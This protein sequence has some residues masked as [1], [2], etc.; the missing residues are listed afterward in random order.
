MNISASQLPRLKHCRAVVSLPQYPSPDS[1]YSLRGK[2]IHKFIETGE[3]P[4]GYEDECSKIVLEGL[5]EGRHEVSFAWNSVTGE[6]RELGQGLGRKYD[7][8][9]DEIGGTVDLV[10]V[11]GTIGD[12]KT[13][14]HRVDPAESNWQ[15]A[16][17]ALCYARIHNLDAVQVSIFYLQED[18][19]WKSDWAKLDLFALAAFE[20]ELRE[21]LKGGEPNPG[22]WCRHCPSYSACPAKIGLIRSMVTDMKPVRIDPENAA[23]ALYKLQAIKEACGHV[24]AAIKAYATETPIPLGDGKYYGMVETMREDIDADKA[25][26]VLHLDPTMTYS[27]FRFAT[28]KTAIIKAHGKEALDELRAA[29]AVTTRTVRT[30][31][32][33][34]K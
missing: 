30:V 31:K 15:L 11:G 5:A 9:P 23:D 6:C 17:G 18:G 34:R 4:D 26:E 27:S 25:F 20:A 19:S 33:Y 14:Y 7:L 12:Y 8:R 28:S 24:E 10:S 16:F 29:G 13:G 2:A 3:L 32:E 1:D 21:A 22:E